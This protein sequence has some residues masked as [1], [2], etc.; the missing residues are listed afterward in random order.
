MSKCLLPGL[1]WL[2]EKWGRFNGFLK[3][4]RL[5]G[6]WASIGVRLGVKRK[7]IGPRLEF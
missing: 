5:G 2:N 7:V 6:V 4:A 3:E 1:F